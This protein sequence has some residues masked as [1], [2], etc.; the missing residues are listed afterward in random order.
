MY[1][2]DLLTFVFTGARGQVSRKLELLAAHAVG[3]LIRCR[4]DEPVLAHLLPESLYALCMAWFGGANEI[5]ICRIDSLQYRQPFAF[6]QV[7]DPLL[8]GYSPGICRPLHFGAVLINPGKE[9]HLFTALAMP[10]GQYIAG[11]GR[12]GV[13]DVRCIIDVI[14]RCRQIKSLFGPTF[15]GNR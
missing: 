1:R 13:T 6:D 14:D 7:I 8:R 3:A 9:P 12:V 5:V 4:I 15:C 11:G 10:T 2:A